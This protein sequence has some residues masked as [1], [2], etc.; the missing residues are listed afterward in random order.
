MKNEQ[1]LAPLSISIVIIILL[2]SALGIGS[3]Q[4]DIL[5]LLAL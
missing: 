1:V 5:L 2:Q 4:K 3:F